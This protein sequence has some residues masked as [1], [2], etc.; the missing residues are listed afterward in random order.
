MK[1]KKDYSRKQKC[2]KLWVP[3][4]PNLVQ[5]EYGV[6]V[7]QVRGTVEGKVNSAACSETC[8]RDH[9]QMFTFFK[10]SALSF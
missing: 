5:I 3:L 4:D 7:F 10:S 1:Y 6:L 8:L 9:G 2:L